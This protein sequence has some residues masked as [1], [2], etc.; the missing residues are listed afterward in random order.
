MLAKHLH[1]HD[2]AQLREEMERLPAF[3]GKL[4]AHGWRD[5]IALAPQLM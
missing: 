2:G 3:R 5:L 4:E 1:S